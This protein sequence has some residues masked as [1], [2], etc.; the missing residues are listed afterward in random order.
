MTPKC[1][2]AISLSSL[3]GNPVTLAFS[4]EVMCFLICLQ[5][6]IYISSARLTISY[7]RSSVG[8]GMIIEGKKNING[9]TRKKTRVPVPVLLITTY[10][11]HIFFTC[12]MRYLVRWT[13]WVLWSQ[14]LWFRQ[15]TDCSEVVLQDD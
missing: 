12:K 3:F 5:C 9:M 13:L 15:I 10:G 8:T 6:H 14:I 11:Q 7:I 2:H 1:Q 4:L